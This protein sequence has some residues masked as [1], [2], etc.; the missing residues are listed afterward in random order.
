MSETQGTTLAE[1]LRAY[2]NAHLSLERTLAVLGDG[3]SKDDALLYLRGYNDA[4]AE[5]EHA[6]MLLRE[7]QDEIDNA[8][9]RVQELE[10]AVERWQ[11]AHAHAG[12]GLTLANRE[13][14]RCYKRIGELEA[15]LTERPQP[16]AVGVVGAVK[17]AAIRERDGVLSTRA[18]FTHAMAQVDMKKCRDLHAE[19]YRVVAIVDPDAVVP[20]TS[21]E[22]EAW[23]DSH[24][25]G[26]HYSPKLP[27]YLDG[28]TVTPL[29]AGTPEPARGE[30]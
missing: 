27:A 15:Q 18:Q 11:A 21:K 4:K 3:W 28:A 26:L 16:A 14:Q 8:N 25:D 23:R 13:Q 19:T 29:Y 6:D 5:A 1:T 2:V 10:A 20:L 24:H 12:E 22:P 17:Y 7:A 9:A 30:A